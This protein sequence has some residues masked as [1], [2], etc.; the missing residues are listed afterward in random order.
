MP[1]PYAD[2]RAPAIEKDRVVATHTTG[3]RTG[4]FSLTRRTFL[5][6]LAFLGGLLALR[7]L[8][9]LPNPSR[10]AAATHSPESVEE[11]L[12]VTS[13][14]NCASAC[15]IKVKVANGKAVGITGNPLSEVTGG[16]ICPRAH[17]G[18]QVL[19]DAGRIRQPL[20]RTNPAKGRN[21]DP[22][23]SPVSWEQAANE[24]TTRLGDLR[25]QGKPAQLLVFNGLNTASD[26]DLINHFA[27]A[28]GTPNIFA[29]Q[30]LESQAIKAGHR[31]ADGN[32]SLPAYDLANAG[33]VL[34]FGAGIL[35]HDKPLARNLRAWGKLRANHARVIVID[36]RY[37][38]TAARADR[39]LPINPGTDAALALAIA[40]VLLSDGLYDSD[41]IARYTTGFDDFRRLTND[42]APE[43]VAGTTGIDAAT[44]REIAG[45]FGRA[46]PAI[47]WVGRG[48]AGGKNGGPAAYAIFCLNALAGS[49][50]V[51]GGILY[52]EDVPYRAMPDITL[53]DTAR[54]GLAQLRLDAV[55]GAFALSRVPERIISGSPVAMAL[56]FNSDIVQQAPGSG[57]WAEALAK[58][59]FYVHA[60]P[61]LTG[62]AQLADII[63]PA[64]TYLE[65]WAYDHSPPGAGF[66]ETRLKQPVVP[67]LGEAR[68]VGDIIFSIARQLGGT[69]A[70]ACDGLG[71]DTA[72]FVQY[73]TG[74]LMA[75]QEFMAKGVWRGATYEYRKYDRIF[76]TPSR[77]FEFHTDKL[78]YVKPNFHGDQAQYPLVLDSYYPLPA[79]ESGCQECAWSQEF[80]LVMHGAGW[81]NF[82]E[83]NAG[84]AR[85]LGIKD[86]DA[87]WVESAFSRLKMKARVI[88]GVHPAVVAIADGQGQRFGASPTELTALDYDP[89]SG[90][91]C[92]FNARVRVY[93]A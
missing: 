76:E 31:L 51:P 35:E 85:R 24:I 20:K 10:T 91:A 45:E 74:N 11:K 64:A 36:P 88:E 93:R 78:R 72:R 9:K 23:W 60:A 22:G 33:C 68:P 49:I 41:F 40:N 70:A 84:T 2:R 57:R 8:V 43:K 87:V 39:W 61:A 5:K 15:G 44:I 55:D 63:L 26:S 53:D 54:Q 80:Y 83:I 7:S 14:L 89:L 52:Q 16:A 92:F 75:W 4:Y 3:N 90:Q 25:A 46:R 82:A 48:A 19:Y 86:G 71:G 29:T 37:S 65:Q 62:T 69:V 32:E 77:K 12:V 50:D 28:Y 27:R 56:G 1:D 73:R 79:M 42:Y 67:P 6:A 30:S 66:A 58:V 21:S 13:C 47:A 81:T 38:V 59:P 34:A 17:I 18:L